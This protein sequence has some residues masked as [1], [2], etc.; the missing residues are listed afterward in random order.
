MKCT[1]GHNADL[2]CPTRTIVDYTRRY[3]K[4][5][6]SYE[7]TMLHHLSERPRTEQLPRRTASTIRRRHHDQ[8]EEP[9]P[10]RTRRAMS[11]DREA[12]NRDMDDFDRFCA[13]AGFVRQNTEEENKLN[14]E[15]EATLRLENNKENISAIGNNAGIV[16][17]KQ[18]MEMNEVK[19]DSPR[20]S[21]RSEDAHAK[22]RRRTSRKS[23]GRNKKHSLTITP[24]ANEIAPNSQ[25]CDNRL[26]KSLPSSPRSMENKTPIF[27]YQT[28][29]V[30]DKNDISID[31][32]PSKLQLQF[33]GKHNRQLS[34]Q[35]SPERRRS[36]EIGK[37]QV[38]SPGGTSPAQP[39]TSPTTG[40]HPKSSPRRGSRLW[41]HLR[42]ILEKHHYIPVNPHHQ[43]G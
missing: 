30:Q 36:S 20:R 9:T 19:L 22:M 39:A 8:N 15:I 42:S 34:P 10:T 7:H 12:S 21:S 5:P 14:D 29:L 35:R 2:P 16:N 11:V 38:I 32:E 6:R 41:T 24:S 33:Y 31:T 18:K 26:P 40:S 27:T 4:Y 28:L 43:P 3:E 37:L 17:N 25:M 1:T 23:K 13:L